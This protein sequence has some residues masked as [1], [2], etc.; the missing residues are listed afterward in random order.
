MFYPW[1]G[2]IPWRWKWLPTLVFLPGKV[3][4]RGAWQA[5]VHR[6]TNSWIQLKWLNM[7]TR[8]TGE[9]GWEW[10]RLNAMKL[11]VLVNSVIFLMCSMGEHGCKSLN[12]LFLGLLPLVDLQ[13]FETVDFN[14]F[15]QHSH[16]FYRWSEFWTSSL[17]CPSRASVCACSYGLLLLF[18]WVRILKA[19]LLG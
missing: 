16:Y 8:G 15:C 10:C 12:R 5:I 9:Q 1:V 6:V 11:S 13:H 14:H 7:H 17:C 2:K 4:G 18:L 3:H 19:G